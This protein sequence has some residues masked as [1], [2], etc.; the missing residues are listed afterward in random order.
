MPATSAATATTP[1]RRLAVASTVNCSTEASAYGKCILQTYTDM[2]KDACK[3]EF[4]KFGACLR[5]T[6]KRKW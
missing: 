3:E 2:K 4:A 5:Q 1:L 6:M